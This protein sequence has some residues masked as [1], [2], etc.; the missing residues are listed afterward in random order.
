MSSA[1]H[2]NWL[3]HFRRLQDSAAPA[4][5]NLRVR[6]KEAFAKGSSMPASVHP[7]SAATFDP[8]DY[9]LEQA[10]DGRWISAKDAR[11]VR[12]A[13]PVSFARLSAHGASC[14]VAVVLVT[15]TATSTI[16][17]YSTAI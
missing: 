7:P 4:L 15:L 3:H 6:L 11:Q 1:I 14:E 5:E 17:L 8:E 2:D 12:A 13:V 10:P 16:R 9:R